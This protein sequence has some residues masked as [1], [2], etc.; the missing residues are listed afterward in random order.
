MQHGL[1]FQLNLNW[2]GPQRQFP[3]F[4][5]YPH[6]SA[7]LRIE[8]LGPGDLNPKL[9]Q[10]QMYYG[11]AHYSLYSGC[12]HQFLQYSGAVISL[13]GLHQYLDRLQLLSEG[14]LPDPVQIPGK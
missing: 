4:H 1:Y 9:N 7:L 10:L 6:L 14:L 3:S 12:P 11:E 8:L 5:F 13:T 2:Q